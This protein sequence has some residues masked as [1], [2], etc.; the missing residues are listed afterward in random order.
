MKNLFEWYT[1]DEIVAEE[2][3]TSLMTQIV[4]EPFH[5]GDCTNEIQACNLC[6]LEIILNDYYKYMI[7]NNDSNRQQTND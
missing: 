6:M 2:F 1:K 3:I 4:A 5:K 7:K